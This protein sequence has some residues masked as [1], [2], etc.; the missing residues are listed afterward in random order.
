[1]SII[2]S[3]LSVGESIVCGAWSLYEV[4]EETHAEVSHVDSNSP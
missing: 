4:L 2:I 3:H 1:M